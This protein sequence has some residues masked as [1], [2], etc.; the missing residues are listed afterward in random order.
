MKIFDSR[1]VHLAA[2]AI[3]AVAMT[4]AAQQQAP[5]AEPQAQPAATSPAPASDSKDKVVLKVGSQQVTESEFESV[6]ASLGPQAQRA[7]SEQGPRPIGEE[8]AL[9]LALAARAEGDHLDASPDVKRELAFE[10]M[11][12]M[13]QAEYTKLAQETTISPD[14]INKYYTAHATEF[15]QAEVRE[16]LVRKKAAGAP[17]S[18]PGM[19]EDAAKAKIDEIRKAVVPGADIQKIA[20]Q[21]GVPNVVIIDTQTRT[22]HKGQLKPEFEKSVFD[23]KDGDVTPTVD[24]PAADVFLQVVSHHH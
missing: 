17:A 12:A 13:A 23:V 18:A 15:D 14:D 7:V 16:F 19:T 3:L 4:G 8:Y 22:V 24:D 2:A 11:K 5:K 1:T 6:V 10:R 9:M 20:K 21:F